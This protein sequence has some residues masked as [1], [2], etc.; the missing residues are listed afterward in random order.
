MW[1]IFPPG[2]SHSLAR[3]RDD[4]GNPPCFITENGFPLPDSPGV[5][6]LDDPERI[7]Y[8]S[9]HLALV[10]AAIASGVDCR[11]YFL[12]SLMDNFEW[13]KGLS[14][15][16]GLVRTNFQTQE[17]TWKKSARWY[18]ELIAR[19]LLDRENFHE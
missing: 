11:G 12:W 14:M 17:R 5:D 8:L 19:N 9:D 2:I 16:F 10:G 1:E 6:P 13:N 7:A 15:R 3:L 18:Q 4:Y